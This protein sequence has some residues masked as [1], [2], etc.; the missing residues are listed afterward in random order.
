MMDWSKYPN[1]SKTEFDCKETGENE[2]QVRF[3]GKLQA[4]RTEYAKPMVIT[5]GYRSPRHSIERRKAKPGA[6]ASGLACDIAVGA[7][8]DVYDLLALALAHGF[9]GI[10][11]SQKTGMARFLH[12]D[13]LPRSAVWSY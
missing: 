4:L 6:H 12:I 13:I 10:G 2:M 1:F 9:T 3:M 7:G 5:S 11:V 8:Q